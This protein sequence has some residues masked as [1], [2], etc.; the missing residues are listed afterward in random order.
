MRAG[1]DELRS[2]EHA[3]EPLRKGA[4]E[5]SEDAW[6]RVFGAD[7][8]GYARAAVLSVSKAAV[9]FRRDCILLVDFKIRPTVSLFRPRDLRHAEVTL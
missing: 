7:A 5:V 2:A 3:I 6:A 1:G 9:T 4:T 8:A